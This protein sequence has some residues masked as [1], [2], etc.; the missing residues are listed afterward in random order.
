MTYGAIVLCGGASSRMG[1]PKALL[2]WRGT[3]M[4]EHVV[5]VL[6]DCVAEVVVVSSPDL[7]L[8]PLPKS[9]RIFHDTEPGRGPL[10]GLR[11]GLHAIAADLAFVTS[12]DAPFLTA[13]FIRKMLSFDCAAAPEIDGFLQPLAA[14]YP[15]ALSSM[16]TA[17]LAVPRNGLTDL[18][19]AAHARRVLPAELP[20]LKSLETFNTSEEYQS[21]LDQS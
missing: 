6:S 18:L 14:V 11:D 15:K 21:A 19:K 17:L 9:V 16:A 1:A 5:G 2:P 10:A 7:K 20:D 8:P 13:P 3:T 4:I 12:T